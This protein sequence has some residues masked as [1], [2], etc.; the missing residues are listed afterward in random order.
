MCQQSET[1]IKKCMNS[2]S[3]RWV[4][5]VNEVYAQTNL[6]PKVT[7]PQYANECLI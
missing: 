1:N 7:N 4:E 3:A 2:W 6:I 5:Y